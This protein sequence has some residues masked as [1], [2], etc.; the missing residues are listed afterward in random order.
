VDEATRDGTFNDG[1]SKSYTGSLLVAH[2]LIITKRVQASWQ[3][4]QA[5]ILR[6]SIVV[7]GVDARLLWNEAAP[8]AEGHSILVTGAETTLRG[9][10]LGVYINDSGSY[11]VGA[12]RF[13]PIETFRP[14]WETYTRDYVEVHP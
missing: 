3:E 14:A 5:A 4:L 13:I 10:L 2:G 9:E 7:A 1:V 8:K 12:G 11:S 6:G